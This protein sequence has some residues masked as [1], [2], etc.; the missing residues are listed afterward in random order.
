MLFRSMVK[1]FSEILHLTSLHLTVGLGIERFIVIAYPLQAKTICR[2]KNG[3]IF[4]VV[5]FVISVIVQCDLFTLTSFKE[6]SRTIRNRTVIGC[7]R[8]PKIRSNNE[9]IVRQTFLIFVPCV[10]LI[11]FTI[12]LVK[13]SKEIQKWREQHSS[14]T[15]KSL[16]RLDLTVVLMMSFIVVKETVIALMLIL[17]RVKVLRITD[18]Y[19]EMGGIAAIVYQATSP[20]NLVIL[21][22]LSSNFREKFKELFCCWF[23]LK[24]KSVEYNSTTL[25]SKTNDKTHIEDTRM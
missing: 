22:T 23:Y 12:L 2:M 16:E 24:K 10:I 13:T 11:V 1:Y 21:F 5:I 8:V 3:I 15:T 25:S 7:L 14:E 4:S 9:Y 18:T 17:S 6:V 19:E 20:V